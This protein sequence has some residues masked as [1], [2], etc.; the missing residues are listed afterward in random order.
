MPPDPECFCLSVE[1]EI[2]A[3]GEKGEDIFEF[4][5]CSPCWLAQEVARAGYALGRF[6]LFLPRYDYARMR[7][8]IEELCAQATGPDWDAVAGSLARHAH[9]EY[10][11][12]REYAGDA[13]ETV[14]AAREP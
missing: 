3:R 11:D 9:W 7:R 8:I 14:A 2:G 5:V 1:A 13:V 6:H 12:Y 10:E 4:L